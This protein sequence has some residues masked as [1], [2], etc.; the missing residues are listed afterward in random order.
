[1]KRACKTRGIGVQC[2]WNFATR[3][4]TR[5][6]GGGMSDRQF[7]FAPFWLDPVNEQLWQEEELIPLRPKLFAVLRH[8]VEHAGRL[9][10]QEDLR[11]VV[12]PTTVISESV[13]RGTIRELR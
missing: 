2:A 9:V 8:L 11:T 3:S 7:L 10:T 1:M 4:Y 13:L 12:W 6:K 5:A